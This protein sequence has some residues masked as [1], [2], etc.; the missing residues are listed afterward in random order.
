[1][2]SKLL[3]NHVVTISEKQVG[4]SVAY[5]NIPWVTR[6]IESQFEHH[7]DSSHIC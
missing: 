4:I 1:M 5:D 7:S 2:K 3:V 6:N